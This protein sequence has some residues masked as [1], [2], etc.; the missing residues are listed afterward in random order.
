MRDWGKL[1]FFLS[2]SPD[3]HNRSISIN[4][5]RISSNYASALARS[6]AHKQHT[7]FNTF[8]FF[9][10]ENCFWQI[11]HLVSN[12]GVYKF[13]FTRTSVH[14]CVHTCARALYNSIYVIDTRL[15]M[16]TTTTTTIIPVLE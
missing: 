15:I 16:T 11:I 5:D 3:A 4:F 8:F 9:V 10:H 7:R 12:R 14:A 2:F 13:L 6:R 1:F